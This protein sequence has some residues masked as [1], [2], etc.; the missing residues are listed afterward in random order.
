MQY[1]IN[2]IFFCLFMEKSINP[3]MTYDVHMPNNNN[4]LMTGQS[5]IQSSNFKGTKEKKISK[6]EQNVNKLNFNEIE[7]ETILTN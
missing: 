2:D 6:R 3:V 1:L 7:W 4:K 5:A